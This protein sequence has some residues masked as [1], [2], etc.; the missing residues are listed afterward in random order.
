MLH[1]RKVCTSAYSA[2]VQTDP[3]SRRARQRVETRR[4]IHEVAASLALAHGLDAVTVEAVSEHV[5]ISRRTF[6]NYFATKEDAVL[7]TQAPTMF[8]EDL[9]RFRDDPET[10]L[11]GRTVRLVATVLRSTVPDRKSFEEHK[12]LM[13]AFPELRDRLAQHMST[14][15]QL[16]SDVLTQRIDDADART[17]VERLPDGDNS[18]RALIMLAVTVMR[19]AFMQD[20]VAA[21]ADKS[22]AVDKAITTFRKVLRAT[23]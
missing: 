13:H 4:A 21:T 10:D 23:L 19:F 5:G 17:F 2:K 8:E 15:E 16:I 12:E 6:F 9:Q 20:P 11:F 1:L 14:S 18:A 7:G 3:L 22:A